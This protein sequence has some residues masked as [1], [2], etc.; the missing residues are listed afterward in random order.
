MAG[1]VVLAMVGVGLLFSI[2]LYYARALD[3]EEAREQFPGIH[4][5]LWHKWYFDELYGVAVVR[6]ALVV[7]HACRWFDQHVIDGIVHCLA[8]LTVRVS[9]WDRLFDHGVVDGAVNLTGNAFYCSGGRL[10]GAPTGCL[11]GYG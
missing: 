11:R 4:R 5:F 10:R 1:N 9:K 8:W 2:L 7:G 3:A 6:P